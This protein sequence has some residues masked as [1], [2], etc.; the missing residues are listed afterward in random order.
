MT[1]AAEHLRSRN[2][3]VSDDPTEVLSSQD[4]MSGGTLFWV[5]Y[6]RD[7]LSSAFGGRATALYVPTL[8]LH[9]AEAL[10]IRSHW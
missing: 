3:G 6:T 10:L 2:D 4:R 5:V 1:A 9:R 8:S 7:A